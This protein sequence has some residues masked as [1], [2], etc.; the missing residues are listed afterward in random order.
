MTGYAAAKW[1]I[2][3]LAWSYEHAPLRQQHQIMGLLLGIF[4]KSNSGNTIARESRRK[5]YN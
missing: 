3:L 5:A 1:V 2:D 4:R